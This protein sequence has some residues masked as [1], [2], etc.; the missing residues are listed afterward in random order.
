[1]SSGWELIGQLV[2][3]VVWSVLCRPATTRPIN[4][5]CSWKS[6]S[7]YYTVIPLLRGEFMGDL[8]VG[9]VGDAWSVL[10]S[11]ATTGSINCHTWLS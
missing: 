2:V 7:F 9:D 1:M 4:C 10:C 11:P 5:H 3:G 8:V 6:V